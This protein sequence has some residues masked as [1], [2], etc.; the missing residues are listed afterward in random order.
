ME[1]RKDQINLKT[2]LK[3]IEININ[4]REYIFQNFSEIIN[5][6]KQNKPKLFLSNISK[7]NQGNYTNRTEPFEINYNILTDTF[8]ESLDSARSSN[9]NQSNSLR[10]LIDQTYSDYIKLLRNIYPI[11]KFNH[12]KPIKSEV[13]ISSFWNSNIQINHKNKINKKN[14]DNVN[15]NIIEEVNNKNLLLDGLGLQ[16]NIA[17]DSDKFIVKRDY[18]ERNC[19]DELIMIKDDLVFKMGLIDKEIKKIISENTK[20][21][22]DYIENNISINFTINKNLSELA[23]LRKS[24]KDLNKKYVINSSKIILIGKKINNIKLLISVCK[25]FYNLY[26]IS[27]ELNNIEEFNSDDKIKKVSDVIKNGKNIIK[28]LRLFDKNKKLNV[29]DVFELEFLK[30]ENKGEQN[31]IL[32]FS[33]SVETIFEYCLIFDKQNFINDILENKQNDYYLEKKE[34]K[35]NN[36]IFLEKDFDYDNIMFLLIYNNLDSN[37]RNGK[38]HNL[39]LSIIEILNLI[40]KDNVDI[41]SIAESLNHIFQKLILN[42]YEKIQNLKINEPEKIY[43]LTNCYL[44]IISNYNYILNVFTYNCGLGIK[45]F[46]KLTNYILSEM[47]KIL[48]AIISSYLHLSVET[49]N[50]KDFMNKCEIVNEKSKK[51]L[52]FNNINW[53]NFI[54]EIYKE[55]IQNYYDYNSELLLK[56]LKEEEWDQLNNIDQVYQD[57]F[58]LIYEINIYNI[59][60]NDKFKEFISLE[61]KVKEEKIEE[62]KNLLIIEDNTKSDNKYKIIHYFLYI[63][64]FMYES[65]F[66]FSRLKEKFRNNI[67]TNVYKIINKIIFT[68]KSI[69]IDSSDGKINKKKLITEKESSLLNSI[70]FLLEIILNKFFIISPDKSLEKNLNEIKKS[71][72]EMMIMLLNIIIKETIESFQSLNFENYP[73]F[74]NKQYNPYILKFTKM[75]KIYDNLLNGFRKEEIIEIYNKEFKE[76]FEKMENVIHSKCKIENENELKQFRKEMNYI[77]K[78]LEMFDLID[79]KEYI[80]KID[81]FSKFVNPNKV[82][83]KKKKSE[84]E[85]EKKEI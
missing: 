48:K 73:F 12:F 22:Y 1:K 80:N 3:D 2:N 57:I 32:E 69:I 46:K 18:L 30:H 45:I 6:P 8:P 54:N 63:L 52:D 61:I 51:Y 60:E 16:D 37:S 34:D 27:K 39:L 23:L 9:N 29:I 33:K 59:E 19:I 10:I 21:F 4:L 35:K 81:T 38:I 84:K 74:Q 66:L 56:K 78:V 82:F 13:K 72:Q 31:L 53:F 76:L 17:F 85:E 62:Q 67:I 25:E 44:I 55:F 42:S 7:N 28:K 75:K 49:I 47:N 70:I 71:T 58:N 36:V 26:N 43:I 20:L 65:F 68:F 79:T 77:K 64:K 40:I 41:N 15:D 50:I 5:T 14:N 11:F 83:K 24:K